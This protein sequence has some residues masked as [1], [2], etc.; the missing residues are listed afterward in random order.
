MENLEIFF[1]P[2]SE[3][4][5]DTC[6]VDEDGQPLGEGWFYWFCEPGCLPSCDPI[7]PYASDMEARH[8]AYSQFA[9]EDE[10][11]EGPF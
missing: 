5:A 9:D 6:F 7:G 11:D 1:I 8:E 4:T 2:L 10:Y 3:Q